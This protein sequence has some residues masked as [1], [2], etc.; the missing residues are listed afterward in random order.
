MQVRLDVEIDGQVQAAYAEAPGH[1]LSVPLQ[2]SPAVKAEYF[3]V[4]PL[5][6]ITLS[7]LSRTH[8]INDALHNLADVASIWAVPLLR[9]CTTAPTPHDLLCS[10]TMMTIKRGPTVQLDACRKWSRSTSS[11]SLR[12]RWG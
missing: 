3:D 1:K 9:E 6:D 11:N 10:A 8:G 4:S 5:C 2:L 12:A 7:H